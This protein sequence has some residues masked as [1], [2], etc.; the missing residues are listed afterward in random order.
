MNAIFLTFCLTT[1]VAAQAPPPETMLPAPAPPAN[2]LPYPPPGPAPYPPGN[3]LPYPPPGP[4]IPIRPP[5][6]DHFLATFVPCPGFHEVTIIHPVSKKPVCFA[7]RLP[8]CPLKKVHHCCNRVT[9]DYGKTKV[10]LIFRILC[11][12]VDVRYD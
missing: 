12:K 4:G 9:Y 2:T 6:L 7:F 10:T 5:T 8:D 11:S 1:E 3:A